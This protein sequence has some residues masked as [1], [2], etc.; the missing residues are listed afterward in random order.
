MNLK[1]IFP[2]VSALAVL[3][4]AGCGQNQPGDK[5]P[6]A[7]NAA[8]SQSVAGAAATNDVNAP[9]AA[10]PAMT[11]SPTTNNPPAAR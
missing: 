6:A 8:G 7:T 5:V 10:N 2:A 3:M 1:S 4:L 9:P 11:N